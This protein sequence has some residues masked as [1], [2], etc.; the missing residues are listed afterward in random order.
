M[1]KKQSEQLAKASEMHAQDAETTAKLA[2]DMKRTKN[3]GY[4]MDKS[5]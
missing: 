1:H 2:K 4:K 3:P 5:Y